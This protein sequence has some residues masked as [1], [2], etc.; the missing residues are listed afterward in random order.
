[1][2]LLR[3]VGVL[4]SVVAATDAPARAVAETA[5]VHG[6]VIRRLWAAARRPSASRMRPVADLTPDLL[7]GLWRA[8][9]AWVLGATVALVT[10]L[11]AVPAGS[12]GGVAAGS[13][14]GVL[15][16]ALAARVGVAHWQ[17]RHRRA[18]CWREW[19]AG[20][21]LCPPPPGDGGGRGLASLLVLGAAGALLLPSAAL[22]AVSATG[23]TTPPVVDPALLAIKALFPVGGEG[24]PLTHMIGQW[25]AILCGLSAGTLALHVLQAAEHAARTG[26]S[27]LSSA[28]GEWFSGLAVVRTVVGVSFL[29]PVSVAGLSGGHYLYASGAGWSSATATGL[30]TGLVAD[31][32]APVT[33]AGTGSLGLSV[34]AGGL[35]LARALLVGETCA[36]YVLAERAAYAARGLSARWLPSATLPPTAGAEN[37]GSVTWDW[38]SRCGTV[39]VPAAPSGAPAEVSYHAARRAAVADVLAAVRADAANLARGAM[40]GSGVTWPQEPLLPRLWAAAEAHDR[41]V[42]TAASAYLAARQQAERQA[43]VAGVAAQGWTSAGAVWR[44]LGQ[45]HAEAAALAREPVQVRAPDTALLRVALGRTW[46]DLV[47]HLD[48]QWLDETRIPALSGDAL[49]A[50]GDESAGLMARLLN[51]VTRPVT[52]YLLA[53]SRGE[54]ADLDPLAESVALGHTI[55]GAVEAGW[56]VDLVVAAAAKN[57]ASDALGI[58]GSYESAT[59]RAN[60]LLWWLWV[61]GLIHAYVLPI[62]PYVSVVFAGISWLISLGEMTMALPLLA[63][64]AIRLDGRELVSAVLRPGLILTANTVVLPIYTV[65][66]LGATHYL[67]PF[68]MKMVNGTFSAAF[69]GSQGGS[70]LSLTGILAGLILSLWLQWQVITRLFAV[71][72]EMPNRLL[73]YWGSQDE[74]SDG[75]NAAA[76]VATSGGAARPPGGTGSR[77]GGG[78]RGRPP[79]PGGG[80]GEGGGTVSPADGDSG[81]G[82]SKVGGAADAE[83][84]WMRGTSGLGGLSASQQAEAEA[85]YGR[86][87]EAHPDR[88]ARHDLEAYVGYVQAARRGRGGRKG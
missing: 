8:W 57:A 25:S 76:L 74:R 63:F 65:L 44:A 36:E 45:V 53:S 5:A 12:W 69:I 19:L 80:D 56:A 73:R 61:V 50:P 1:M 41:A 70:T 14:A 66:A 26:Q 71:I 67:L 77:P 40:P 21:A 42:M 24:T 16:A 86:W 22:A 31:V 28:D 13:G 23:G 82:V 47:A 18:G 9:A 49:A 33:G 54:R 48:R 43:I 46:P 34:E 72:H 88:A 11:V 4:G 81:G 29:Y 55:T 83:S 30:A 35:S 60:P 3:A 58:D 79:H 15:C 85:A 38:G 17:T 68:G 32:L 64:L 52:E 37:S 7:P 39:S 78:G 87:E 51:P 6:L 62:I 59:G 20:D 2:S 75:K 84:S 10:A 27:S